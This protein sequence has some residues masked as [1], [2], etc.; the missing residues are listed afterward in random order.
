MRM[1][2]P[3]VKVKKIPM[4]QCIACRTKKPKREL[5]RIVRD[6]EGHLH[7]DL[8][9]KS[10]GRGAYICVSGACLRKATKENLF[11]RHLDAKPDAALLAELDDLFGDIE[12]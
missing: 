3:A 8:K 9:G 10:P 11:A 7:L 1:V 4:R 12:S 2:S 5:M 6:P